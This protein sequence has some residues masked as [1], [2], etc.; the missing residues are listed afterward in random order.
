ML[1]PNTP[2]LVISHDPKLDLPALCAGLESDAPSRHHN[3][4]HLRSKLALVAP[5]VGDIPEPID[6]TKIVPPGSTASA[7]KPTWV[8]NC[9]VTLSGAPQARSLWAAGAWR[10]PV[11]ASTSSA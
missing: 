8:G 2:L 9:L 6:A 1:G 5:V 7:A 10:D 11:C 3:P 4:R